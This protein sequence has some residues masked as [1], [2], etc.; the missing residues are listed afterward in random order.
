M[1]HVSRMSSEGQAA[2]GSTL[3]L[4]LVAAVAAAAVFLGTLD[5]DLLGFDDD[6]YITH[7]PL[8]K[9]RTWRSLP[10][11]LT[12]RQL[13]VYNPLPLLVFSAEYAL[14]GEHPL[15]YHAVNVV[16]HGANAALV[17]ALV[18]ALTRRRFLAFACALLWGVHP[19][20]VESVAWASQFKEMLGA[21]FFLSA[22]LLYLGRGRSRSTYWMAVGAAVCSVLC[23]P[24]YVTLPAVILLCDFCLER[25]VSRRSL[26]RV[27]PFAVLSAAWIVLSLVLVREASEHI[28]VRSLA[29]RIAAAGYLL[30]FYP[31]K[32]FW[33]TRL[34]VTYATPLLSLGSAE[35][36]LSALALL[37]VLAV[38]L[39]LV[40]RTAL[41]LFAFLFYGVTI[42]PM[43]GIVL[44]PGAICADR[45]TYLA[46]I[47]LVLLVVLAFELVM[48]RLRARP[49]F[50]Y[51]LVVAVALPLSVLTVA[52]AEVWSSD[53][54]LWQ[55]QLRI[56]PGDIVARNNLGS[57]YKMRGQYG[58]A[59]HH[60]R[61]AARLAPREAAPRVHIADVYFVRG[62]Y[63]QAARWYRLA[64]QHAAKDPA[65]W[66]ALGNA[67]L[68]AGNA[69]AAVEA[70]EK[71]AELSGKDVGILALLGKAL[72][73]AGRTGQAIDAY[74]RALSLEPG[75]FFVHAALGDIYYGRRPGGAAAAMEHYRRCLK[76]APKSFHELPRVLR[77]LQ[78]L[79]GA[80]P[81][82]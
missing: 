50:A 11:L 80:K 4:G 40:R 24:I 29:Q 38:C 13:G 48:R 46:S 36:L 43:L 63:R 59:L 14:W 61:I 6:V 30:T 66:A 45:Y 79:E 75:L 34:T 21:F 77:R 68:I 37:G 7:N 58:A 3:A 16:F 31:L 26:L 65:V 41:P 15:G 54:T 62:E 74:K 20:R 81:R 10:R 67:E 18:W 35:F 44:Y 19:L 12:R 53:V 51:L 56:R 32:L 71:A 49:V 5:A 27:V 25:R 22:L 1:C 55:A 72:T 47:G 23:K 42:S 64:A 33:P 70:L 57:A 28:F 9:D 73:A 60:L 76:T 2:G 17:F 52:R 82:P 8:I 78:E 69:G 39:L